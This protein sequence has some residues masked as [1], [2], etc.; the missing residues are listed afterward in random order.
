MGDCRASTE[1]T[2]HLDLRGFYGRMVGGVALGAAAAVFVGL[3]G[4]GADLIATPFIILW[5]LSP[6]FARWASLPPQLA[7]SKPLPVAD[8]RA[9]R[10]IARRTWRFFESV[11]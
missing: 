7:G 11:L 4:H 2:T 3:A 6:A 10:L 9:L 5:M 8:A 1:L